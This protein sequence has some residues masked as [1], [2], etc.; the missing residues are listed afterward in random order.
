MGSK[1]FAQFV[2]GEGWVPCPVGLG[3]TLEYD[4]FEVFGIAERIFVLVHLVA[5][6]VWFER[7]CLHRQDVGFDEAVH[8]VRLF[9]VGCCHRASW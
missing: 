3:N 2:E 8:G 7:V 5:I 1:G 6:G 9:Q 4:G